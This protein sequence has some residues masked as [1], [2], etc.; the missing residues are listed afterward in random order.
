MIQIHYSAASGNASLHPAFE[1]RI[2]NC[3]ESLIRTRLNGSRCRS[4]EATNLTIVISGNWREGEFS[5]RVRRACCPAFQTE[6]DEALNCAS[7]ERR[8]RSR[9]AAA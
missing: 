7:R 4:C 3:I 8:P 6:A 9:Y 2:K 1:A 5:A